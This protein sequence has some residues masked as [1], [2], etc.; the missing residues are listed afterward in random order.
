LTAYGLIERGRVFLLSNTTRPVLDNNEFLYLGY[1]SSIDG[2]IETQ[3]ANIGYYILN[4]S[5]LSPLIENQ[6][7]IYSCGECGIYKGIYVTT[8]SNP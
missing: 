5:K 2:K 7:N 3:L 8:T 1:M 4:I 6:D